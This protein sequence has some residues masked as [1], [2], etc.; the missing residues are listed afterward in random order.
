MLSPRPHDG[1]VFA[2]R[3]PF[4]VVRHQDAAQIRMIEEA[5]AEE[6]EHLALIPIGAAPDS[7]D[8]FNCG[9]RAREAALQAQ[10]FI[11]FDTVQVIDNFKA[12]FGGVAVYRGDRADAD[13]FLII[14]EKSANARD[15]GWSDLQGQ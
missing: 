5:Y 11:A 13:E 8:R 12:G 4:P 6:V 7:G 1:I 3:M 9:V 14:L 10:A 2:Q 15:F